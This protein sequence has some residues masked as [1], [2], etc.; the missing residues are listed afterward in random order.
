MKYVYELNFA[1]AWTLHSFTVR[2]SLF[3]LVFDVRITTTLISQ[4]SINE[5]HLP[6]QLNIPGNAQSVAGL[7]CLNINGLDCHFHIKY[8]YNI[9]EQEYIKYLIILVS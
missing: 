1:N 3:Q 6:Q 4:D 9:I 5:S 2:G 8:L 7:P